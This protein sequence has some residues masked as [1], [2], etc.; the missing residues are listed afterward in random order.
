MTTDGKFMKKSTSNTLEIKRS[1]ITKSRGFEFED[2][3]SG[4]VVNLNTYGHSNCYVVS[5]AGVYSF[6]ATVIGNGEFGMVPG[7]D[8]HTDSPDIAPVSVDLLWEDRAGLIGGYA[9]DAVAGKVKFISTSNE[10][11]ALFAVKDAEGNI[12]WSWHIWMTDQPVDQTYVNSAGTFVVQDRNLG[13]T[14]ADRGTGDEWK[15]AKGILYQWGRK[16]P[17]IF[18]DNGNGKP[19]ATSYTG[20]ITIHESISDPLRFPGK[21]YGVWES[22]GNISLWLPHQK[23]IYDPCPVGY[24]VARKEIWSDFSK[25]GADEQNNLDAFNVSGSHDNGWD[26]YYDGVNTTYIPATDVIHYNYSY[27]HRNHIGDLWSSDAIQGGYA[28]RWNYEYYSSSN[29]IQLWYREYTGYGLA[30]RCMKDEGYID[31]SEYLEVTQPI[32]SD[33]TTNSAVFT[34]KYKYSYTTEVTEVGFIYGKEADL[35]DGIKVVSQTDN[36]SFSAAVDNLD[37]SSVYYVQAYAVNAKGTSYSD[38]NSFLTQFSG[39]VQ[40][41][42][43]SLEGT[44]NCYVVSH[45]GTYAFTCMYKGNS[46]MPVGAPVTAETLWE[47]DEIVSSLHID[48]PY[49]FFEYDGSS[50]GN[51]LIAVK[52]I[53][54][55]ILWSWHI[56]A[57]DQPREQ[58]YVNSNGE[59]YVLDRNLGATRANHGMGDEWNESS[60]LLYQWGRKDPF[61]D[62][63]YEFI[64][65]MFTIEE[66]I[67]KPATYA[68]RNF[69]WTNEWDDNLWSSKKTVYD[70]CPVGYKVVSKDIWTGFT[71]TGE[72]VTSRNE[73]NAYGEFDHGWNFYI[74]GTNTAWYPASPHIGYNGPFEYHTEGASIWYNTPFNIFI[75]N[76]S[77]VQFGTGQKYEGYAVRCMKDE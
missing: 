11:N 15:N 54:G 58:H 45:Q 47:T 32:I 12:L 3:L 23:T 21:Y 30:L 28:C 27:E 7:A 31:V 9:Y 38:I 51:A 35:S 13:A 52:D 65:S 22:S 20:V 55:N 71:T 29:R 68:G 44:A 34:S 50:R 42:N 40:G 66:S 4:T 70:P 76:N 10:G 14:R 63:H 61:A 24:K 33:V 46:Y 74:D 5:S 53:D 49:V 67:R 36:V 2:N 39:Y 41:M 18:D 19:V 1:V 72:S 16:D 56:W 43:L 75:Y 73:I 37:N 48:G 6:D 59:Y 77:K 57:T 69:P 62:G 25:T 17:F 60:G 8:F 64:D 26:F